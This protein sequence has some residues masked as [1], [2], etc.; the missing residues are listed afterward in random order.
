M[1]EIL[2]K[3]YNSTSTS[4]D[5]LLMS[6]HKDVLDKDGNRIKPRIGH[7]LLGT[8]IKGDLAWG[9][10]L[11]TGDKEIIRRI[12]GL[13]WLVSKYLDKVS[14]LKLYRL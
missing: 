9:H 6:I 13:V 1:K 10:H 4:H 14:R 5:D 8:N 7:S 3:L 2:S 11:M 12:L